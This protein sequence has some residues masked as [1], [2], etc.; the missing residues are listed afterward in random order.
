MVAQLLLT[1]HTRQDANLGGGEPIETSFLAEDKPF[2][3]A[4]CCMV[5]LFSAKGLLGGASWLPI[6]NGRW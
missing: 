4:G 6:S 2:D 3:P 5:P 1:M